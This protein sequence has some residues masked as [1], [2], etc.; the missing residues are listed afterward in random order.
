[1]CEY[2]QVHAYTVCIIQGRRASSKRITDNSPW[3]ILP[4]LR[5]GR[6]PG[7][8]TGGRKRVSEPRE[9]EACSGYLVPPLKEEETEW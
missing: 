4:V 9:M 6:G 5:P 2:E 8:T 3:G 1:M 7:T